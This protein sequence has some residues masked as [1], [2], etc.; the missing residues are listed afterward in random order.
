MTDSSGQPVD[1]NGV[2]IDR[3]RPGRREVNPVLIP[4]LRRPAGDGSLPDADLSW[5]L[6]DGP[7]V[8]AGQDPLAAMRGVGMGVLLSAP[9]WG[10]VAML[11]LALRR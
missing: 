8:R 9:F 2:A 7:A 10:A 4:L 3:R 11:S 5:H 1:G 6:Q